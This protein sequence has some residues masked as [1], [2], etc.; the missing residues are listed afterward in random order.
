MRIFKRISDQKRISTNSLQLNICEIGR[1]AFCYDY[2][3]NIDVYFLMKNQRLFVIFCPFRK[4]I[5]SDGD[6]FID[7]EWKFDTALLGLKNQPMPILVNTP[8]FII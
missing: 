7:F 2:L 4:L 6:F 1:V 8:K 5:I 3:Q